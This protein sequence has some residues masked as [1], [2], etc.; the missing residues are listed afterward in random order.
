V[1]GLLE[2]RARSTSYGKLKRL[3]SLHGPFQ[4]MLLPQH[5]LTIEMDLL[6]NPFRPSAP[7]FVRLP[8]DPPARKGCN[9]ALFDDKVC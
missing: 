1:V 2:A 8:E 9:Y 4:P 3:D 7:V 6:N 5:A